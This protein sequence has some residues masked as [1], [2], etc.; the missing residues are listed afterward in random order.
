MIG[1]RQMFSG[2]V[3]GGVVGAFAGA[4]AQRSEARD[5]AEIVRA[6]NELR[7]EIR[8]QRAFGEIRAIRDAQITF[9][10]SNNKLPDYIEVGSGHW[11]AAYDWHVRWQQPLTISRD[12]NGRLTLLLLSTQLILR[13][14]AEGN[15]MS[16]PF[17][18][19]A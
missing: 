13:P 8:S 18:N 2:G 17:D 9:L 14:D 5:V 10:R 16:L 11:F 6:L 3:M 4:E 7:D 19:R 12:V 1:R 15:F